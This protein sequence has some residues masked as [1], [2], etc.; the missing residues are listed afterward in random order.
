MSSSS[1]SSSS[2]HHH[3]HHPG[4]HPVSFV[5]TSDHH[6]HGYIDSDLNGGALESIALEVIKQEEQLELNH[7]IKPSSIISVN[8]S[9]NPV[10][11]T[12]SR[13]NFLVITLSKMLRSVNFT[14]VSEDLRI[15]SS[16]KINCIACN[17]IMTLFLS[18]LNTKEVMVGAARVVCKQFSHLMRTTERVCLGVVESFKDDLDYI[19]RS[20]RLTRR[21]MCGL[22]LGIECARTVTENLNWTIPIP[23]KQ[24]QSNTINRRSSV[25]IH[26]TD[27]PT[28]KQRLRVGGSPVSSSSSSASSGNQKKYS[29]SSMVYHHIGGESGGGWEMRNTGSS[30]PPS[31]NSLLT[32]TT[33]YNRYRDPVSLDEPM[34]M[35][36][37]AIQKSP[38]NGGKKLISVVHL[39]DIHIDPYYQE[40]AAAACGEPLCCRSTEGKIDSDKMAGKWGDYRS[41]DTPIRTVRHAMKHISE[42]Y[43]NVS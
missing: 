12:R 8:T 31:L 42:T 24:Q 20:S 37:N 7:K 18:P 21:E 5:S 1:S 11:P 6:H 2:H 19:K 34:N 33:R 40:G 27:S 3:S 32:S 36:N 14:Q 26:L 15:G 41:C 13:K 39:T 38:G 28:T 35:N 17:T 23:S 30:S 25:T 22:L 43:P 29:D 9:A 16:S 4:Y 10:K